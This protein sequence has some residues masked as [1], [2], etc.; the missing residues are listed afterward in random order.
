MPA[1]SQDPIIGRPMWALSASPRTQPGSI[2][3]GR[4]EV[5]EEGGNGEQGDRRSGDGRAHGPAN[6]NPTPARAVA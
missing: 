5:D 6:G 4:K 2:E 3:R 1:P